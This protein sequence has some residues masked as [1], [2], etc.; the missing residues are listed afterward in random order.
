MAKKKM[1]AVKKGKSDW[2]F[3]KLGWMQRCGWRVSG[4][5][6]NKSFF[7]EEDANAYLLGIEKGEMNILS[8]KM[9][10]CLTGQIVAYVDGSFDEKI[11]RYASD[12]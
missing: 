12:A 10:E 11:G 4:G 1:Y 7:T 5:Q 6:N 8:E 2:Y 3:Y 9:E